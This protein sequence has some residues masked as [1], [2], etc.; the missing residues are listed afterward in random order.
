MYDCTSSNHGPSF[1]LGTQ[2]N[3][4]GNTQ[5]LTPTTH[6]KLL[7]IPK[8]PKKKK[9]K[10]K[11]E[12]NQSTTVLSLLQKKVYDDPKRLQA[13]IPS[14]MKRGLMTCINNLLGFPVS[15]IY[16]LEVHAW[17]VA[18]NHLPV[19]TDVDNVWIEHLVLDQLL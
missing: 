15:P 11:N 5:M 1:C 9:K 2:V 14:D 13:A 8:T 19:L 16:K 18:E 6:P 12:W 17:L 7:T 4:F 3:N 10:Q